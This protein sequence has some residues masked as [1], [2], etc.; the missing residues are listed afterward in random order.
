MGWHQ[1]LLVAGRP[2]EWEWMELV[3]L[4]S[5][6]SLVAE[7]KELEVVWLELLVWKALG[8]VWLELLVWMAE[9]VRPLV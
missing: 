9:L 5:L 2:L 6:A 4:P 1:Q 7:W 8:A 3:G